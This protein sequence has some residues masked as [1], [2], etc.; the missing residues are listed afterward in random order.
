MHAC[1]CIRLSRQCARSAEASVDISLL[2]F[3]L[4]K[5]R[6]R[7]R[8]ARLRRLLARCAAL[9]A[10]RSLFSVLSSGLSLRAVVRVRDV[11]LSPFAWR[12]GRLPA[13]AQARFALRVAQTFPHLSAPWKSHHAEHCGPPP[14]AYGAGHPP[15]ASDGVGAA[16]PVVG[17][18]LVAASHGAEREPP[19]GNRPVSRHA[20][21]SPLT[22]HWCVHNLHELVSFRGAAG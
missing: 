6:P 20:A 9:E 8:H 12:G 5:W 16:P 2:A 14:R 13:N 15:P 18:L 19:H 22:D 7:V 1:A 17:L 11:A 21:S 10:L 3:R 4:P